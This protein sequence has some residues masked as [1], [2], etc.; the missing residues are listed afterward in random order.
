MS[1][2]EEPAAHK[3]ILITDDAAALLRM[4]EALGTDNWK[5]AMEDLLKPAPPEYLRGKA[6]MLP[7]RTV[8]GRAVVRRPDITGRI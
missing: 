8:S 2:T 3:P 1:E 7:G 5:K 4:A 6:R